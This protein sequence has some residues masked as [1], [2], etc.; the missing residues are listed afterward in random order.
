[1]PRTRTV[2]LVAMVAAVAGASASLFFEPRIAQR[3]AGTEA[4]QRV[5]DAA[6]KAKAAPP[7]PGVIVGQR[8]GIDSRHAGLK[9]L[10]QL[11]DAQARDFHMKGCV[12]AKGNCEIGA[13]SW[14]IAG[15]LVGEGKL[16][17]L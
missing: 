14:L 5:L 2:L 13:P 8:G 9:V 4:G 16:R 1:M 6:L 12:C 17:L 3:L 7:P 10:L 15:R 11:R